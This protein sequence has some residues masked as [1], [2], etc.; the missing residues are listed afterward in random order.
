[1]VLSGG[2]ARIPFLK[3]ILS[4]KHD[5]EFS[6]LNPLLGVDYEEG[7]FAEYGDQIE[8]IAPL[9]TVGVGL[10]LRKARE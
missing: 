8:D 9:L 6:V 7:V 4:E 5:M 1:V 10:A 2:G 3:D